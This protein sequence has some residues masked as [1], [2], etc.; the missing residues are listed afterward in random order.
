MIRPKS[1]SGFT[2]IE[3]VIVLGIIAILASIL[4]PTLSKYVGDARLRRAQDDVKLICSAI[5]QLQSDTGRYPVSSDFSG[6]TK[7]DVE[8]LFGPGDNPTEPD[9]ARQW[10]SGKVTDALN[11]Q[12]MTNA[13]NYPITGTN[14]WNGPYPSELR[15]DPWGNA[16][17]LNVKFLQPSQLSNLKSVFVLSAGP[18][19]EINTVFDGDTVTPGDDDIVCRI[20]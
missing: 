18:N 7:N 3:M 17:L 14:K 10:G 9:A 5:G 1:S 8:T 13:A 16:Y 12:I 6:G 19:G 11:D 2:L 15:A 20:K 4:V